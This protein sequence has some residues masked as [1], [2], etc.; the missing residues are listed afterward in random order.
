MIPPL[1]GQHRSERCAAMAALSV[2]PPALGWEEG[3]GR[4]MD[5]FAYGE[6]QQVVG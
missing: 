3:T 4:G 5:A 1:A 2:R 6:H